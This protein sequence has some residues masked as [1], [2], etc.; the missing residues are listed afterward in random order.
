MRNLIK[1]L[2]LAAMIGLG[3]AVTLPTLAQAESGIYLGFG[4]HHDGLRGGVFIGDRSDYRG[5][6]RWDRHDRRDRR[7]CTTRS[8]VNK[9]ERMG[10]RR[11]RVVDTDRRT[12]KVMGS[13]HGDR[14]RVTFAKAPGCPL[15]RR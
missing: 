1:N 8:A 12:I 15:V 5:H 9:A 2:T 10:L 4:S 6:D 14:V 3:S 11:V 7:D 13:R